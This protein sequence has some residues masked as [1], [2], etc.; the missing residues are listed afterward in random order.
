M[1]ALLWL[2][3]LQGV[4]GAFDIVYHH[5][6]T[7]RLTWRRSAAFELKLHGARNFLYG[8]LYAGLGWLRWHGLWAWLLGPIV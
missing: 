3:A 4:L 1:E 6:M 2:L 8:V 5:E 7:E